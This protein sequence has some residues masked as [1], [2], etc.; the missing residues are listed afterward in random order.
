MFRSSD[1]N[2]SL[3]TVMEMT[4]FLKLPPASCLNLPPLRPHQPHQPSQ[5]ALYQVET[6]YSRM[7]LSETVMTFSEFG[8][9]LLVFFLVVLEEPLGE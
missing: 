8:V 5:P 7:L 9:L 4:M 1:S 3:E 6:R 2:A